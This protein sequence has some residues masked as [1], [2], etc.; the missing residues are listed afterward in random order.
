MR[1][2]ASDEASLDGMALELVSAINARDLVCVAVDV[3]WPDADTAPG[4]GR[5]PPQPMAPSSAPRPGSCHGRLVLLRRA[6]RRGDRRGAACSADGI[7]MAQRP[8]PVALCARRPALGPQVPARPCR[9]VRRRC[10]D[11]C[12]RLAALAARRIGAGLGASPARRRPPRSTGWR[13]RAISSSICGWARLG[14]LVAVRAR[15]SC[16]RAGA[17]R[18]SRPRAP[19]G[20]PRRRSWHGDRRRRHHRGGPTPERVFAQTS[21][22]TLLTP[23]RRVR[24]PASRSRRPASKLDRARQ[25]ARRSGATAAPQGS[26]RPSPRPTAGRSSTTRRRRWRR[27]GAAMCWL[28]WPAA[29]GPGHDCLDAAAAR[30]PGPR[31]GGAALRR[32]GSSRYRATRALRAV[33][34][35]GRPARSERRLSALFALL[36]ASIDGQT[37]Q[38]PM[39]APAARDRKRHQ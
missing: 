4:A 21:G 17:G 38:A 16:R 20:G 14:Q 39:A 22:Q 35:A 26:R 29:D 24:P 28:A 12:C 18:A 25:A 15:T 30:R 23:M 10:D 37:S 31:R 11:W 7:T 34:L 8:G 3:P 6:S 5:V 19:D 2:S 33:G 9:G 27:P 1:C 36:H 13:S 32:V